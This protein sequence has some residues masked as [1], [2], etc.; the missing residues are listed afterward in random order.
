M[1][2]RKTD[3]RMLVAGGIIA[4]LA[5]LVGIA[6]VLQEAEKTPGK[7]GTK[8]LKPPAA[9]VSPKVAKGYALPALLIKGCLLDLGVARQDVSVA[10]RTVRVRTEALP[11]DERIL[12]A[13]EPLKEAGGFSLAAP[14]HLKV[15]VGGEVWDVVFFRATASPAR[16]AIIVD[17]MGQSLQSARELAA[18]DADLTF[19]VLPDLPHSRPVA[20]LLHGHGREL[21]LHLPMQGNGK[22]PGPGAILEGMSPGQVRAVLRENIG[23]VPYIEGVNNHMGSVVTADPRDMRPVFRELR[24]NGLFFVDSLTTSGSVCQAMAAEAKV[25][26]IARDVF[27]DN[28]QNDSYISGQIHK[29]VSLSL[30]HSKAVGICH[31]YPE[32]IAVL[33]REAPRLRSLGVEI[34]GVSALLEEP[35]Q[36]R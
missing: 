9:R 17:D 2:K 35:G 8:P 24:K 28:E 20:E 1:K 36:A 21:L 31:P 22:D 16:C 10:G 30:K 15:R 13:F 6:L 25:P 12:N 19:A 11:P 34:V 29:L 26:F 3:P 5:I 7:P 27:L 18:I 4:V 23:K 33:Q 14:G 32:T